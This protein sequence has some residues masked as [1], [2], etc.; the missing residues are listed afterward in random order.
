MLYDALHISNEKYQWWRTKTGWKKLCDGSDH[1]STEEAMQN[2]SIAICHANEVDARRH[3]EP[4]VSFPRAK[5]VCK[6]IDIHFLYGPS[7][8]SMIL[9]W[10][11]HLIAHSKQR[12]N[13]NGLWSITFTWISNTCRF[14]FT[15]I[16]I[17]SIVVSHIIAPLHSQANSC[18]IFH[19]NHT[20]IRWKWCFFCGYS[21]VFYGSFDDIFY[22]DSAWKRD[23]RGASERERKR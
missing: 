23:E 8:Y 15:I 4:P 9:S 1:D 17:A 13:G 20:R 16:F 14:H 21:K 19:N 10:Y 3:T 7:R 12:A 6:L 22:S 18:S 11:H 5:S 2:R